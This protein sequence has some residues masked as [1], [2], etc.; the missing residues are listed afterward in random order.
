M[1]EVK[2]WNRR[3]WKHGQFDLKTRKL[4]VSQDGKNWFPGA[5]MRTVECENLS[6]CIALQGE[7]TLCGKEMEQGKCGWM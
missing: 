4:L 7:Y 1:I 3:G 5:E 6:E 2:N